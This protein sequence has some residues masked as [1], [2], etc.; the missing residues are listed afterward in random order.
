MKIIIDT[1]EKN[2]LEFPFEFV[3]ETINQKLPVGDYHV[4]FKDNYKPPLMFE[5]KS[6]PDLYGTLGKGYKRFK[7]EI[8]K[9]KELDIK[10]ILIIEGS[11]TKVSKGLA[12]SDMKG[13]TIVKR[14]FTLWVKHNLIVVF[15][16]D[17]TEMARF[18][19]ETYC[20]IGRL[21][22]KSKVNNAEIQ[23]LS[24][25]GDISAIRTKAR[26]H[27]RRVNL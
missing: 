21:I 26:S 16:K 8:Q 3:T 15:C 12:R 6:L 13:E 5:R 14:L 9:S 27:N 18:I 25:S 10:L 11:L 17:R 20:A 23:D 4:E 22:K 1:R 2:Q 19:Y 24:R 7:K